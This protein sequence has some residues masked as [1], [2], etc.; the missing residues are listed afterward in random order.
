MSHWTQFEDQRMIQFKNQ[1]KSYREMTNFLS[2]RSAEGIRCRYN[3]LKR[4]DF[5]YPPNSGKPWSSEEETQLM[6]AVGHFDNGR[7]DHAN[8]LKLRK[9]IERRFAIS[10]FESL[11]E[12]SWGRGDT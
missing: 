4:E 5:Q 12:V 6:A 11:P 8:Q 10:D 7:T 2:D 3:R 1:N 9:L